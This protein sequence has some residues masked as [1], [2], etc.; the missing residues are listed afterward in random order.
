[1]A[2]QDQQEEETADPLAKALEPQLQGWKK[3]KSAAHPSYSEKALA[4]TLSA[5]NA[6]KRR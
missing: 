6:N 1:M 5:Q 4:P 3:A 2:G